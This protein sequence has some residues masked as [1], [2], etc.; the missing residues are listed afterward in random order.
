MLSMILLFRNRKNGTITLWKLFAKYCMCQGFG[1]GAG[2]FGWSR[3]RLYLKDSCN[4]SRKI[5][6]NLQYSGR[7]KYSAR[8]K[9]GASAELK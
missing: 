2:V 3:L 5:T 6:W 7:G 8:G 1:A 4:I 9:F